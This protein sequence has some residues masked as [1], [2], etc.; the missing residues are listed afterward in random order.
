MTS[1][2]RIFIVDDDEV[3]LESLRRLLVLA[4]FEVEAAKDSKEVITRIKVFKPQL[5][6]LDLLMPGMGGFEICEILNSDKQT[7]GIPIIILSALADPADIKRAYH[8]GVVG[9]LG[10]PYDFNELLKEVQ[11]ALIYKDGAVP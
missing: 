2:K 10:K 1:K 3:I 7:S 9:Y 4:G 8:L 5:I 11:K 6:L